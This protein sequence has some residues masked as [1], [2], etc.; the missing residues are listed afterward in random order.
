M[1]LEGRVALGRLVR[2]VAGVDV[3]R[4][5]KRGVRRFGQDDLRLRPFLAQDPP[6][7]RDRAAGAIPGDPVIEP[8][9]LE[10]PVASTTVCPG[11]SRPSRSAASMMLSARRSFTDPAGLNASN[12][13]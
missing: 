11:S 7:P 6:D 8:L 1:R 10:I 2:R 3:A 5:Q 12:F 13:T 4:R 9:A